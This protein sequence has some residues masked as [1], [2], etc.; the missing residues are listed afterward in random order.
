MLISVVNS[1][2]EIV[3]EAGCGEIKGCRQEKHE[4][5]NA[6]DLEDTFINDFV[7]PVMEGLFGDL[8]NCTMHWTRDEILCGLSQL[9]D[10][11]S[12]S[13]RSK[14]QIGASLDTDMIVENFLTK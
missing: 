14:L 5:A 13:W 8:V 7:K 2:T 10:I 3:L 4:A 6:H 11:R 1:N 9:K 12:P